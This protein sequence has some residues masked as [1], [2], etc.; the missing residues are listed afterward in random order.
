MYSH[1]HFIRQ[2]LKLAKKAEGKTL[3]NPMVGAVLVCLRNNQRHIIGQGFHKGYG[4]PHAEIEAIEDAKRNGYSDLSNCTLYV[5]LE[6]CC[7][8]GKTPPCTDRIL[9]EKIPHVIF[10]TLDPFKE[11]AGKGKKKLLGNGVQVEFG[12]LEDECRELNK[13]FFKH[14][15][16]SLPWITLK[17]AQSLDGKIA[18]LNGDSQ[19]ISSDSSRK[20]VHRWRT[21]Y[22]AVLVGAD[23]VL[24]DNPS[25]NVRLVR[26]RHPKRIIL[27]GRLRLPEKAAVVRDALRNQTIILTS[28]SAS[29]KKIK[30]FRDR[31]VK[32]YTFKTNGYRINIRK[33]LKKI[34]YEEKITS[35]LVEGG[36]I[37]HG[38][39]LKEKLADEIAVFIAP[40]LIGNGRTAINANLAGT[41]N[42]SILLK[43]VTYSKSGDDILLRARL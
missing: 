6:P 25:L 3:T 8:F 41:I 10:G 4:K 1:E 17:M 20:L 33:A 11:V 23:T 18:T 38:E 24:K 37:V 30:L 42:R 34:L 28:E 13:V 19:W 7:H 2:T 12:F 5:N 15:T 27:D 14:V 31:G 22:D 36:A 39:F 35:V 32:V 40:K 26:G 43:S 16:Y 21:V 9:L 29:A